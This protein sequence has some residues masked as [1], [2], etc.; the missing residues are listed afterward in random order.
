MTVTATIK[1][2]DASALAA[3][4][5]DEPDGE[6]V[7][8]RIRDCSLLAPTSLDYEM[9]S[10]CRT[11]LRRE[12]QPHRQDMLLAAYLMPGL[13]A[14]TVDVDHAAVLAVAKPTGLTPYDASYLWLARDLGVELVTLDRQLAAAAESFR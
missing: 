11:N 7:A 12:P 5:F 8:E 10:I 1:V 9:A 6:A 13:T 14:E 3:V 2:I 4:V